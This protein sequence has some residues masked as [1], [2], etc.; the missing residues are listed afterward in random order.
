MRYFTTLFVLPLLFLGFLKVHSST[1]NTFS[2]Q[3]NKLDRVDLN[4]VDQSEPNST[5]TAPPSNG[6]KAQDYNYLE[7]SKNSYELV[8]E[9]YEN[10]SSDGLDY[11]YQT[12][13]HD[14]SLT[15]E[16]DNDKDKFYSYAGASLVGTSTDL[17]NMGGIQ[18][19]FGAKL[20]DNLV[21][22]GQVQIEAFEFII[23][24]YN[25]YSYYPYYYELLRTSLGFEFGYILDLGNIDLVPYFGY[26]HTRI[27]DAD[28]WY[29][30]YNT[31][32]FGINANFNA[33]DNLRLS[34]GLARK[35]DSDLATWEST[36]WGSEEYMELSLNAYIDIQSELTVKL[37]IDFTSEGTSDYGS[38][39]SITLGLFGSF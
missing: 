15:D 6:P 2:V 10:F 14:L 38:T 39:Q 33:S 36:Y 8:N 20:T 17:V 21:G 24:N 11:S 32:A 22:S 30:K 9:E 25:G 5:E 4:S 19:D 26:K 16:E 31:S 1:G 23:W 3:L 34:F 13:N 18:G 28:Y 7:Q 27:H 37:G 12:Y 35:V 29:V